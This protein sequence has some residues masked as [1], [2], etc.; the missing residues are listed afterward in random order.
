MQAIKYSHGNWHM[1][2]TNITR[3][4]IEEYET[5]PT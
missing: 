5:L 4:K 3:H 2:K 1:I